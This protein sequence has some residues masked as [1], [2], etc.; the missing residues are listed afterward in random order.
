MK[1]IV[2]DCDGVPLAVRTLDPPRPAPFEVLVQV[3]RITVPHEGSEPLARWPLFQGGVAGRVMSVGKMVRGMAPGTIVAVVQPPGC[4][5][6]DGCRTG[7]RHLCRDARKSPICAEFVCV[8]IDGVVALPPGIS[9]AAGAMLDAMASSR[10]A[11][12]TAGLTPGR[13]ILVLGGT[14]SATA[15]VFW[16]NELAAGQIV[17]AGGDE[18]NSAVMG[19]DSFIPLWLLQ[20]GSYSTQF[21]LVYEGTGQGQMLRLAARYAKPGAVVV[22]AVQPSGAKTIIPAVRHGT[23]SSFQF[24]VGYRSEDV[25]KSLEHLKVR[26]S[27]FDH[28]VSGVATLEDYCNLRFEPGGIVQLDPTL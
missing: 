22:S 5:D 6:C 14:A 20:D 7:N 23:S 26:A 17:S 27:D 16:A 21:D 11:I 10:H 18:Q 9:F 8:H 28:A 3:M 12:H 4:G 19:C 25:L 1:A 24:F 15:A 13:S 2:F